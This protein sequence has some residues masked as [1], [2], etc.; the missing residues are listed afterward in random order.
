MIAPTPSPIP[1]GFSRRR[2]GF[3]DRSTILVHE[4]R[5]GRTGAASS[6]DEVSGAP[7][8]QR[9]SQRLARDIDT[10]ARCLRMAN[11]G[12]EISTPKTP[13]FDPYK[14]FARMGRQWSKAIRL[15][16]SPQA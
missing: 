7:A 6:R 4:P 14:N 15:R 12:N 8:A 10:S 9:D 5:C 13:T 1:S 11:G 16:F 2:S 3:R